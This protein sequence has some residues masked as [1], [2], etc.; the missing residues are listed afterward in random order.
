[1]FAG[2]SMAAH[3]GRYKFYI[4]FFVRMSKIPA[5][6]FHRINKVHITEHCSA[7]A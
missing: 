4:V 7:I 1:M 5:L 2:E 3:E 6:Y